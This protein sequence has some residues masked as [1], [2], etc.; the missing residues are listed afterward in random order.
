MNS[1]SICSSI[2]SDAWII[3][4]PQNALLRALNKFHEVDIQSSTSNIQLSRALTHPEFLEIDQHISVPESG[5]TFSPKDITSIHLQSGTQNHRELS[6]SLHFKEEKLN[7]SF[8]ATPYHTPLISL[9]TQRV[10]EVITSK[11]AEVHNVRHEK[12]CP[13][14]LEE[15][16]KIRNN[17]A[18]H[19]LYSLLLELARSNDPLHFSH[20]NSIC[21]SNISIRPIASTVHQGIVH[22]SGPPQHLSVDL[23]EVYNVRV[24]LEVTNGISQTIL[25]AYNSFGER[26]FRISQDSA[27]S[28][29]RW[30]SILQ[31]CQKKATTK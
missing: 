7:F 28:F 1:T 26:T 31:S 19:P 18:R 12:T 9:L 8:D 24:H 25:T 22:L 14:C 27:K 23:T 29:Q 20:D 5:I 21:S 15:K 17:P 6:L 30:N 3:S 16:Q 10:T 4:L 11:E 13:C 2:D